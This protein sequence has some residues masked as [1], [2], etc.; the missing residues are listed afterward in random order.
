MAIKEAGGVRLEV[1]NLFLSFGGVEALSGISFE[2]NHPEILAIIGP[3]GAGKTCI[4]NCISGFYR[5]QK[6]QIL[7]GTH[8]I[9][10]LAPHEIAKIGVARTFQ[11]TTLYTGLTLLDNLMAARH[12]HMKQN[13]LAG[14]IYFNWAQKEELRQR[15]V[16][17]DIIDLL[18]MESIRN[19][20]V[21][22][23]SYGQRKRVDL[24][25][26]LALEPK[27]LLLDEPMAGMNLDEKEDVA[28][29][30]ID[31]FEVRKIPIILIEHDMGVVM[32]LADR[33][34]VIDF[35][36]KIA[37]GTPQ[38]IRNNQDVIKAYLGNE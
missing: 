13:F 8:V 23:L 9:N 29:F 1:D 19:R 33:I 38:E 17:E 34:L 26:A 10:K 30:I 18:E 27:M 28:R 25:R 31:I 12:I 4:L 24:G 35:G 32:D 21:G 6:G 16:V 37:E 14:G 2:I 36:E 22:T 11:G 5:P 20:I 7:Y 15:E 3:N